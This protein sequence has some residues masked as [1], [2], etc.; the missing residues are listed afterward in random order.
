MR[1]GRRRFFIYHSIKLLFPSV[2]FFFFLKTLFLSKFDFSDTQEKLI[3]L[4]GRLGG[5]RG[6]VGFQ[7]LPHAVVRLLDFFQRAA[8][9]GSC[10]HLWN[11]ERRSGGPSDKRAVKQKGSWNQRESGGWGLFAFQRSRLQKKSP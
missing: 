11:K 4:R 7:Y 2:E 5:K 1:K 3:A 8:A 10:K 9:R 6:G